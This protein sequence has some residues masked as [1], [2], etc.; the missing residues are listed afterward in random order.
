M[1]KGGIGLLLMT[2]AAAVVAWS[3]LSLAGHP[4]A[5]GA[6]LGRT[7]AQIGVTIG[8]APNPYN[9]LNT[10]LDAKQAQ[11][12]QEQADLAVREA[13]F[14][15]TTAASGLASETPAIWYLTAAVGVLAFLVGLNYFL[16][17]RRS[18]R[19]PMLPPRQT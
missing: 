17:W 16:D 7:L 15:S 14:A 4:P 11:I 3:S 5:P 2:A 8:V 10:Q 13:V 19:G 9:T 6:W 12:N 18:L 1:H